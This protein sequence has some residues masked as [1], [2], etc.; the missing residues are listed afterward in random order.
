[1]AAE[2]I[3]EARLPIAGMKQTQIDKKQNIGL[4]HVII[5]SPA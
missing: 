1:M 3:V 2:G 4:S 5:D